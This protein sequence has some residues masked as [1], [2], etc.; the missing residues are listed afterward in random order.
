MVIMDMAIPG[1]M[2]GR[3]AEKG[4]LAF[5]PEARLL[6]S[7]GYSMDPVMANPTDYGFMGTLNRINLRS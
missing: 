3:E 7:R 6:V 4:I 5:D 1:G 2:G